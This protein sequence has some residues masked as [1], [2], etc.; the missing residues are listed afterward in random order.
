MSLP[1][2]QRGALE[3]GRRAPALVHPDGRPPSRSY[4]GATNAWPA[5]PVSTGT[6]SWSG[7][8]FCRM[9]A[10]PTCPSSRCARRRP[11]RPCGCWRGFTG[12]EPAGPVAVAQHS[13][14][15]MRLVDSGIP[16]V[17]FPLCNP[18]GYLLDWRYP[19]ARRLGDAAGH[20]VGDCT[21]LLPSARTP[22]ARRP[23]GPACPEAAALSDHMLALIDEYP[24]LLTLDC[25]K[26][27]WQTPRKLMSTRKGS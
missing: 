26:T 3:S 18:V 22:A 15:F 14:L 21:H 24:P 6:R 2:H 10:R 1:H 12:E 4:T 17:L 11:V 20:S 8:S 16:W 7:T 25:T 19:D 5:P 9:G 13:D 27:S 23:E